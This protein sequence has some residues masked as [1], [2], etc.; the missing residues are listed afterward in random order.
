MSQLGV[1]FVLASLLVMHWGGARPVIRWL[2]LRQPLGNLTAF[3]YLQDSHGAQCMHTGMQV[4][5]PR[6]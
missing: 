4:L 1:R 3:G 6:F 2:L 5:S